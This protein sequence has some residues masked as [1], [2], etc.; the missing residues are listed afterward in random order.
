[1]FHIKCIQLLKKCLIG[2]FFT[3]GQKS[4]TFSQSYLTFKS[5]QVHDPLNIFK[6]K[7]FFI[8]LHVKMILFKLIVGITL[9]EWSYGI[10]LGI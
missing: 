4:V 2:A 8:F 5:F 9:V 1:M 10:R 6:L 7:N 3:H